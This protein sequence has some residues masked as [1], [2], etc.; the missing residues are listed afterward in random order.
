L[1]RHGYGHA[2]PLGRRQWLL[3]ATHLSDAENYRWLNDV[4]YIGSGE[5]R[6]QMA[7][8]QMARGQMARRR[9]LSSMWPR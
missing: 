4:L 2:Y 1:E 8:G 5:A 7:R 6:G 9:S 3:A